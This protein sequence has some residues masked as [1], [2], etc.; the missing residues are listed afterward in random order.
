MAK[1]VDLGRGIREGGTRR[2]GKTRKQ[3][4]LLR[5]WLRFG[6]LSH[7]APTQHAL[8]C[9]ACHHDANGNANKVDGDDRPTGD[10]PTGSCGP[11]YLFVTRVPASL[12]SKGSYAAYELAGISNYT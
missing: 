2:F 3:C 5:S 7:R 12:L 9:R 11:T 6:T 4:R 10:G 1:D 8:R